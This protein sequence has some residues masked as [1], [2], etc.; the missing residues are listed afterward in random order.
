[1]LKVNEKSRH[2]TAR[3]IRY[4][5]HKNLQV[6]LYFKKDF[7]VKITQSHPLKRKSAEL[8]FECNELEQRINEWENFFDETTGLFLIQGRYRRTLLLKEEEGR[9]L[10]LILLKICE[11]IE[12]INHADELAD[13]Q[14]EKVIEHTNQSAYD[15]FS[16]EEKNYAQSELEQ[17]INTQ[18]YYEFEQEALYT[19]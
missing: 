1:M 17:E 18:L 4:A 13:M 14:N 10:Q 19:N 5:I 11:E 15:G 2:K 3:T 12:E 6:E 9:L 7:K 16:Q 8:W